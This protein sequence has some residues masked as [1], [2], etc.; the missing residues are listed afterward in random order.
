MNKDN[1]EV[2]SL[3]KC[4]IDECIKK[5]GYRR[6]YV[7]DYMEITLQQLSNWTRMRSYPKTPDLYKLASF[8]GCKT[9]DLYEYV[10]EEQNV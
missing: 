10:K 8:L 7:A 5:V 4:N 3:L 9:D 2:M 6:D 1:N